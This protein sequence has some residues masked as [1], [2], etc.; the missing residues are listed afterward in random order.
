MNLEIQEENNIQQ[1]KK[2]RIVSLDFQRGLAIWVMTFL[3]VFEHLYDY[4]WV[5]ENPQKVFDLPLPILIVGGLVGFFASWNAYFLLISSTVNTLSMQKRIAAGQEPKKVVLKQ[6]LTGIGI[7]LVGVVDESLLYWGYF[8]VGFRTG[9]WSNTYPLWNGFFSMGTLQIIGWSLIITGLINYLIM[10]DNGHQK[11]RRNMLVYGILTALVITLTPFVHS[12]VDNMNWVVP[13]IPPGT[14]VGLGDHTT[15]PSIH[16]QA[17]N[18]SL[19][20][21]LCAL[22][23][24]DMQPLFPYL[25]TSFVGAMIG[26]TLAK[27][28]P[29]KRL[30][31]KGALSGFG[32]MGL[33]GI[34]IALGFYILGNNRPALGNFLL[35]LGGQIAVMF[36][37]LWLIEYRGKS[38]Q[39]AN[40]KIV[41]HLRM[42]GMVSLSIYCLKIVE[43]FPR[44]FLGEVYNLWFSS[45]ANLL[46]ASVF[47]FGEE[48]KI[49]LI[50]AYTMVFFELI[51]HLWSKTNFKY[52]FEWFVIRF[53]GAST[54]SISERLNVQFMMNDIHWVNYKQKLQDYTLADK[55]EMKQSVVTITNGLTKKRE[56]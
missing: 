16:F 38:E 36:F 42:W 2:E 56:K 3:H 55:K 14:E 39:F 31:L 41:K 12:L 10:Q 24:G 22:L 7:L 17:G 44:W 11:Y 18:A 34:F 13:V 33:G 43:L 19:K 29:V 9:N 50:A 25:A 40:K 5:K 35:M 15:W 27:P 52:S 23:A 20:A 49:I 54:K 26:L 53:A 8:G 51:V 1:K 37:F 48:Y 30:P 45:E 47:G 21:M 4:N 28:K 32:C 6:V 46:Q